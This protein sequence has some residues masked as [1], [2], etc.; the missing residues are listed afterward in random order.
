MDVQQRLQR[1]FKTPLF[2]KPPWRLFVCRG[3]SEKKSSASDCA[4]QSRRCT[5][6]KAIR[7]VLGKEK[8]TGLLAAVIVFDGTWRWAFVVMSRQLKIL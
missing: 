2:R 8:R 1:L 4:H 7:T 3:F 6:Q 5:I